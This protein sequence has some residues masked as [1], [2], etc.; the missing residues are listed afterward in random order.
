VSKGDATQRIKLLEILQEVRAI[1]KTR[2]QLYTVL[3]GLR[4]A[5]TVSGNRDGLTGLFELESYVH[6]RVPEI[7][8]RTFAYEQIPQV[9]MQGSDFHVGV[10]QAV[11]P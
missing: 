1:Y 6:A 9:H 8:I 3:Q 5:D 2:N 4:H 10:V 7:T 11:N